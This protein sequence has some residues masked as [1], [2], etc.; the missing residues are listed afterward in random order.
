MH[1]LF[2]KWSL[3][4]KQNHVITNLLILQFCT[5]FFANLA[6]SLDSDSA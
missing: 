5:F 1:A 6:E 2:N 4:S 3:E